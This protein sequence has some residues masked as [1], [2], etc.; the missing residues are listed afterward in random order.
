MKGERFEFL[1]PLLSAQPYIK[2]VKWSDSPPPSLTHDFSTFRHDPIKGESLTAWQA[3][4]FH[5]RSIDTSP[6]LTAQASPRANGR[7][8]V[9]RSYRY[10]NAMYGSI[11]PKIIAKHGPKMLFV[12]LPCEHDAFERMAGMNI[13]RAAVGTALEMA[14]L[15]AGC[16]LFVGNQ[17]LAFWVAIGLGVPVIQETSA[18]EPNSIILRPNA[19]YTRTAQNIRELVF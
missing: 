8:V 9:G 18:R 12:G 19:Q 4:H 3:R 11:W 15:I 5:L 7:V 14:E 13:E 1:K 2:G 16:S 10:W 6:W 17:S